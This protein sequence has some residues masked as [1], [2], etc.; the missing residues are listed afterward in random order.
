MRQFYGL[1]FI[2][3]LANVAN[4]IV[5]AFVSVFPVQVRSSRSSFEYISGNSGKEV[6]SGSASGVHGAQTGSGQRGQSTAIYQVTRAF[7]APDSLVLD[8]FSGIVE[9]VK[10]FQEVYGDCTIEKKFEV[11]SSEP[12]PMVAYGMKL[13][14]RLEQLQ[15]SR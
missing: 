13:G 11:P 6:G 1:S 3:L 4:V 8:D 2:L 9:A 15:A 5:H 10:V 7:V 12:W 14:R